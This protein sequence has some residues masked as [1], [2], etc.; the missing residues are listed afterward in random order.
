MSTPP[1]LAVQHG[2][3][4]VGGLQQVSS[5][6]FTPGQ[7]KVPCI[8]VRG[9]DGAP[10]QARYPL[11]HA[12]K[13]RDEEACIARGIRVWNPGTKTWNRRIN[14]TLHQ[15][16][17]ALHQPRTHKLTPTLSLTHSDSR[18]QSYTHPLTLTHSVAFTRS[19]TNGHTHRHS[20]TVT[21]THT[22]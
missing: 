20:H 9:A 5:A 15:H 4:G 16:T 14:G 13:Q 6:S 7:S 22:V 11:T 2:G 12:H 17:V 1:L 18:T 3:G 10:Y 19:Y 8:K 21:H